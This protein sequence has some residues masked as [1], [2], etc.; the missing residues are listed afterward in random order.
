M[1]NVEPSVMT[2][3][4]S[5]QRHVSGLAPSRFSPD[6]VSSVL[7][8]ASVSRC[9][10][11]QYALLSVL[12][13]F[14][15]VAIWSLALAIKVLRQDL[16]QLATWCMN[17][18]SVFTGGKRRTRPPAYCVWKVA[19]LFLFS[20]AERLSASCQCKLFEEV[21][22]EIQVL[23]AKLGHGLLSGVKSS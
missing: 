17:S 11:L 6:W 20:M 1:D 21:I 22:S 8:L 7:I 16:L 13:G 2:T 4:R 10:A 23:W 9:L 14:C 18:V 15:P 3:L 12:S 19:I 5:C